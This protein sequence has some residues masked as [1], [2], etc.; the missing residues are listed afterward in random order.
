M[1]ASSHLLRQEKVFA[2]S[3]Y[4]PKQLQNSWCCLVFGVLLEGGQC[5]D[6]T[7]LAKDTSRLFAKTHPASGSGWITVN[8]S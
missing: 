5:S 7:C 8:V 4:F 1:A 2:A 6:R 3:I